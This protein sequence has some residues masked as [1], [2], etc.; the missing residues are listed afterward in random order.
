M[1]HSAGRGDGQLEHAHVVAMAARHDNDVAGLID[2][3]AGEHRLVLRGVHVG[4]LGKALAV[5]ERLAVIHHHGGEPRQRSDFRQALRNMA[6]P[7]MKAR[8]TG[9]TGST[10]TSSWPPQMRPLS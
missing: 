5:G 10:K 9:S 6:G 3:E 7:E 4:R 2:R 8:G 1:A